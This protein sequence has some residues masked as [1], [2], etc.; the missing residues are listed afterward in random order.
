VRGISADCSQLKQSLQ[1]I[2]PI[3][4]DPFKKRNGALIPLF[5]VIRLKGPQLATEEMQRFIDEDIEL[6][7]YDSLTEAL[8]LFP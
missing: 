7:G 4:G 3:L 8:A 1:T 5:Q 6:R 2:A